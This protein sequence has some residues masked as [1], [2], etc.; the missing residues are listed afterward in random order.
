MSTN[1]PEQ[2]PPQSMALS[3]A[4]TVPRLT[5]RPDPEPLFETETDACCSRSR[6]ASAGCPTAIAMRIAAMVT[7]AV[8]A[9]RRPIALAWYA[10]RRRRATARGSG[11]PSPSG[12][13]GAARGSRAWKAPHRA[14]PPPPRRVE[15]V[16]AAR[17]RRADRPPRRPLPLRRRP[18]AVSAR[19][20]AFRGTP[21]S[22]SRASSRSSRTRSR[23]RSSGAGQTA[24]TSA[25]SS[26]RT[27]TST[28]SAGWRE[29]RGGRR[30]LADGVGS[31]R[32]GSGGGFAATS[33]A[34]G[35]TVAIPFSSSRSCRR[36]APSPAATTS[37]GTAR[38]S[39][40]RRPSTRRD[41]SRCSPVST[42][43]RSCAVETSRRH[44][45]SWQPYGR[46]SPT[47]APARGSTTS[48]RTA[49]T[50]AAAR[51]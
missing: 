27:S 51:R 16:D 49:P 17:E 23:P 50:D 34:C 22:V 26:S 6:R 1:V 33:P 19:R 30:R 10:G 37:P 8:A 28:T 5:T 47:G 15:R 2:V 21:G 7:P 24:A 48:G 41:T 20:T 32:R 4:S 12:D 18:R 13:R 43:A 31:G 36:S 38:C 29:S 14:S 35:P 42:G 3:F 11:V 45:R 40:C 46:T 44:A 39:S 25:G 9:E